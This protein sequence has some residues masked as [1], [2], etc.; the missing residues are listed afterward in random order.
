[1]CL[2][3]LRSRFLALSRNSR[4]FSGSSRIQAIPFCRSLESSG[5]AGGLSSLWAKPCCSPSSAGRG[6]FRGWGHR[7]VYARSPAAARVSARA[8]SAAR[9]SSSRRCGCR[10]AGCVAG[11]P[12]TASA[13]CPLGKSFHSNIKPFLERVWPP[14]TI[15]RDERRK[16][17]T[18]LSTRGIGGSIR[19]CSPRDRTFPRPLRLLVDAC[20]RLL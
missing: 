17:S 14:G 2:P 11:R 12:S 1:M 8:G 16:P 18:C 13:P 4:S 3:R 15:P 20:V 7:P 10:R 5:L 19:T 9:P 6:G